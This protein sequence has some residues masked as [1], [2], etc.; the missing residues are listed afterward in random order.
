[1]A[2]NKQKISLDVSEYHAG[3][4]QFLN[5]LKQ[6][7]IGAKNFS[8]E[9]VKLNKDG[10][11]AAATVKLMTQDGKELTLQLARSKK[12][13]KEFSDQYKVVGR[14][15]K[16]VTNATKALNSELVRTKAV[17]ATQELF[18]Q[19]NLQ[20]ID[21]RRQASLQ[22]GLV[23]TL[24]VNPDQANVEAQRILK[25]LRAGQ[26]NVETGQ[27]ATIQQQLLRIL[28][29]EKKIS[30][31]KQRQIDKEREKKTQ[32]QKQILSETEASKS[33]DLGIQFRGV[34]NR[35]FR[36][37][38]GADV[39][40]VNRYQIALTGLQQAAANSGLS[41]DQLR[42][43]FAQLRANPSALIGNQT[44]E[45]QRLDSAIRT[46]INSYET[47]RKS[48][49]SATATVGRLTLTFSGFLRLLQ[50]QVIH[51]FMGNFI[52]QL[53]SAAS[54]AAKLSTQI[55][56]IQTI[57]QQSGLTF[58]DLQS[59][60]QSLAQEFNRTQ[61]DVAT[62]AY[63]GFSNQ[64]I[65]TADDLFLLQ[66]A[67]RLSRISGASATESVNL[68]SSAMNAFE[69]NSTQAR[70]VTNAFFRT[71]EYGRV[72]ATDI[73]NTFGRSAVSARAAG[74]E[75]EE[76]LAFIA[77]TTRR[78]IRPA[79]AQTQLN[80]LVTALLKPSEELKKLV[81]GLGF[82]D[83]TQLVA[84]EGF[85]G[86]LRL[87][88]QES[89]KGAGRLAQ[90]VP[91]VRGLRGALSTT[92]TGL[93]EFVN[94]LEQIRG[95]AE[96]ADNAFRLVTEN[97]GQRF[98][99]E[100]NKVQ[101]YFQETLGKGLLDFITKFSESFGGIENTV[102]EF[103]NTVGGVTS[104]FGSLIIGLTQVAT[105]GGNLKGVITGLLVGFGAIKANTLLI[106]PAIG[107]IRS[108]F[109]AL[110]TTVKLAGISLIEY[111]LNLN[112]VRFASSRTVESNAALAASFSKLAT[113]ITG[114]LLIAAPIAIF[115]FEKEINN[116]LLTAKS[117]ATAL[118]EIN[119][120][121]QAFNREREE[122][123]RRLSETETRDFRNQLGETFEPYQ[124]QIQG[125]NRYLNQLVTTQRNRFKELNQVLKDNAQTIVDS[126]G[127]IVSGLRNSIDRSR[128]D[129][130]DSLKRVKEFG[131]RNASDFFQ[132]A[133]SIAQSNTQGLFPNAV[134]DT[135]FAL[136]RQRVASLR[137]E[138]SAL[139]RAGDR[140][141]IESARRK[142][143]E[144]RQLTIQ[145]YN[146][147]LNR[148]R[149]NVELGLARPDQV[150][151][152]PRGE[153]VNVVT[154]DVTVLQRRLEA[155]T[156]AE[157][158]AESVFQRAQ[159]RNRAYN[160]EILEFERRRQR[161]IQ[162]NI[163]ALTRFS[164]INEQGELKPE[165]RGPGGGQAALQEFERL[166]QRVIEA[167]G[168]IRL[169]QEDLIRLQREY[170]AQG[171]RII[172]DRL[173]QNQIAA[174][175]ILR[176]ER[177]IANSRIAIRDQAER[178]ITAQQARELSVRI[179]QE[180]DALRR[181]QEEA[182][183]ER[184]QAQSR[185]SRSTQAISQAAIGAVG[186]EATSE[187]RIFGFIRQLA[188]REGQV[189]PIQ[190]TAT[191]LQQ[192]NQAFAQDPTEQTATALRAA[193]AEFRDQ[194]L[195]FVSSYGNR[196]VPDGG[197]LTGN[198][199]VEQL[200]RQFAERSFEIGDALRQLSG[201]NAENQRI[202]QQVVQLQGQMSA[203][204]ANIQVM[205]NTTSE[206]TRAVN[207]GNSTLVSI[208]EGINQL[209]QRLG[210]GF[211]EGGLI[212]G[213]FTS[214]G[215]DNRIIAAR[216][217]EFVVNPDSTAKFYPLLKAINSRSIPSF[218]NGGIVNNNSVGDITV[219]ISGSGSPK[220]TG[221]A[222]VDT[223]K[224][225]LRTNN[226]RL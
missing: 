172:Q 73:A 85:I 103:G 97:T 192:A 150:R 75:Y 128:S 3:V 140:E 60:V 134:A 20:G 94:D 202:Q 11:V 87:L 29:I 156:A 19:F 17:A 179:V 69:L 167:T 212:G 100:L 12:E 214:K 111:A 105:V 173:S 27:N 13:A 183:R 155:I 182:L 37:V 124:R 196:V 204:P 28:E 77:T 190:N 62:A 186:A 7:Q 188:G 4:V 70:R 47:M 36:P 68:L 46:V 23:K 93:R 143:E 113:V 32:S 99:S 21:P 54:E 26:I 153:Q 194:I 162:D 215:P 79:E 64:V 106:A 78:G 52:N 89:D 174:D 131:D 6:Q 210:G 110:T 121:T 199:L 80:A 148:R 39:S 220:A 133:L 144:I 116:F 149:Q 43:R 49:E 123:D 108:G 217:G 5:D 207:T 137:E 219:N 95:G 152:G 96:S 158:N 203:L 161:S 22:T 129:I 119:T 125:I 86:F 120:A 139:I 63:Q 109:F 211:A 171:A 146:I 213:E 208:N 154:A 98:L 221:S 151:V 56:M 45:T 164:V 31:E 189:T 82:A 193:L 50:V 18:K 216:T 81:E 176:L 135:Q 122:A 195:N 51:R 180:R 83:P 175:E 187:N 90:L 184:Q 115:T 223:L 61:L 48:G 84:Q 76:A 177:S 160:Q 201:A 112:G 102:K 41:L 30:D 170:G 66:E 44:K 157:R 200:G 1:M 169:S 9:L 34:V 25:D 138:I 185:I 205:I 225:H 224:R 38:T 67:L 147:D 104:S 35:Q 118:E 222:V 42:A 159:E 114:A 130:E 33:S 55:A 127:R 92:G 226:G 197:G 132:Q 165:F 178:E 15:V 126:I 74:L 88:T 40:A 8:L 117:F 10:Q 141:S 191:A 65:R 142:F 53:Q 14:S 218:A 72:L 101:I 91:N 136:I 145:E 24:A 209:V 107:A 181:R 58:S 166:R 206:I 16:E 163:T 71:F 57:S 198:Q 168:T 59:N 2:D